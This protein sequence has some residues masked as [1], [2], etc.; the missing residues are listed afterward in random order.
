MLPEVIFMVLQY[1]PTAARKNLYEI[2]R[3]VSSTRSVVEI[4]PTAGEGGVAVISL[5]DWRAMQETLFLEQV[6]VMDKV[7]KRE[8]DDTGFTDAEDIDW[9][10]L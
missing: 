4:V 2:I 3:D 10:S 9:E 1:T 6:G 8:A 5:T 7:R